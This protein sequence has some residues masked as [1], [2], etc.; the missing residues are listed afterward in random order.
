MNKLFIISFL[1]VFSLA[2]NAQ[3]IKSVQLKPLGS[4]TNFSAIAKLGSVLELSFDDLEAD[5]KDYYY[6]VEHM[7]HNWEPSNLTSSQYIDGFDQN[8]IID[9]TNSFNTLQPYT[10]YSVQIP[11]TNT[12]ITKSGNYLISIL[13]NDYETVFTRRCVFYEDATTVGVAVFRSRNT[14]NNNSEQTVQFRVSHPSITLNNP[15]QEIKA[16]LIQNNDWNTAITNI[17]PIFIQP[18]LL[19]YNHTALTNYPGNNEFLNF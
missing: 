1:G 13:N 9:V 7:T 12:V 18:N 17:P 5:N 14:S 8:S 16:V 6:K 19:I 2:T 4:S 3:N 15:N 11:N 10:H